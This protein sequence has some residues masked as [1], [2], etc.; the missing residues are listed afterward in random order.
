ML[1]FIGNLLSKIFDSFI[2]GKHRPYV[3]VCLYVI[4]GT[5]LLACA[6]S[7]IAPFSFSFNFID[8]IVLEE[9]MSDSL[10]IINL[11]FWMIVAYL[12]HALA[13][14]SIL[15]H[16]DVTVDSH[17]WFTHLFT[18][19][20]MID[21]FC[22]VSSLLFVI[23]ISLQMYKTGILY[24]TCKANTIYGWVMYKFLAFIYARFANKNVAIIKR[25]LEKYPDAT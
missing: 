18:I 20:D 2:D 19:G 8:S 25:A 16:F 6:I 23:T 24:T 3:S 21:L 17:K 15:N 22:S 4:S 10:L 12:I 7:F 13:Q 9:S 14:K 11:A 5:L 1:D